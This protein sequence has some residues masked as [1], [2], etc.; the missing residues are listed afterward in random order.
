MTA[1]YRVG[2]SGVRILPPRGAPYWLPPGVVLDELPGRYEGTL[3]LIDW[4]E[5]KQLDTYD[6]KAIHP[7]M[8]EDKGL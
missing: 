1:R 3:E 5:P 8:Y 2:E 4:S 7:G 6:D